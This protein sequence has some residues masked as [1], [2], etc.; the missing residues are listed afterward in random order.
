[1]TGIAYQLPGATSTAFLPVPAKYGSTW[2]SY[3]QDTEG[4]PGT[5][6]IPAPRDQCGPGADGSIFLGGGPSGSKNMP[7]H[8]YPT[9]YYQ[10]Q[11]PAPDLFPAGANYGGPSVYSDNQM[12]I[13]ARG[14]GGTS[15]A[16]PGMGS[17]VAMLQ[18]DSISGA[19]PGIVKGR[20][21]IIL[22]QNPILQPAV[23]P[24]WARG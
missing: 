7:P 22:G 12:P 16:A 4:Q 20:G 19:G 6:G 15:F 8:W 1:M 13:P 2:M 9:L 18:G 11:L 5:Q 23:T 24:W 17:R 3:K 21:G 14:W 10:R